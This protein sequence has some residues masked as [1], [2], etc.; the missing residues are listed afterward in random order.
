MKVVLREDKSGVSEVVG[1]ILILAMTVVLFST[2]IL[3]V[4]NIP[5]PTAQNRLD[6]QATLNPIYSPSTGQEIGV[7]ITL[8]HTGGEALQPFS[9]VIYIQDQKGTGTPT[10]DVLHLSLWHNAVSPNGLLDGTDSVWNI[11]ERWAYQNNTMRSTDKITVTIVDTAQGVVLFNSQLTPPPG[12]RP[13]VFLNVWADRIPATPTIDPLQSGQPIYIMA[14]VSDPDGDLNPNS[15]FATL[16]MFYGTGDSCAQPQ[17]MN[18]QGSNGD[19]V[20]NDGTFTLWRSCINSASLSWDGALVLLNATDMK[21]HQTTTRFTLHITLGPGGSTGGGNAGSGRPPNLRWNGNQGYNI[22]NAT[23]WDQLGFAAQETRTFKPSETVVVVVGSLTLENT[24]GVNS[25]NLWDPY[26]GSPQQAVVYGSSK[27]VG[28]GTVPSNT[29]AFSFYEFVNG[30]Y[31]YTYRFTLNTPTQTNFYVTPPSHPPYYYFASYPLSV[32]LT[33]STGDRFTTTDSVNIT[34]ATGYMRQ[35]PK[36]ETFSDSGFTHPAT[37]FAST[38]TMYVQVEMLTVNANASSTIAFGNIMIQDYSGGYELNRAPTNG[39]YSNLPICPPSGSCSST[40]LAFWSIPSVNSYRFAVNLARVNQDPWVAGNQSY[41]FVLSSVKDSDESYTSVSTQISVQAP[42][43][44][45]DI[46]T[47]NAEGTNSAW[48]TKDYAYFY[49]DYNGYDAWKKLRVDYCYAGSSTSGVAGSGSTC[50]QSTGV[51]VAFGD[52]WHDGTL[53]VAEAF[54]AKSG[55]AVEVFRRTVDATGAVV[56]LPVF[57]NV[58]A[59]PCTAITAADVTGDGIPEVICGGANGWVWYYANNGNWTTVYVD[60]PSSAPAILSIKVADFNGDGW[61][62]IVVSG[63]NGYLKWYPNLGYGKFQNSGITDNWFAV[64]EQTVIGNITSGSYLNTYVQDGSYEQ[65]TES[66]LNVP[67][68]TG[69]A[70]NGQF[71]SSTSGWTFVPAYNSSF[72]SWGSPGSGG[73][74]GYA[75]IATTFRASSTVAGYWYQPFTVSG[76]PPYTISFSAQYELPTNGATGGGAV[77]FYAFVGS[78]SGVPPVNPT[79]CDDTGT[80]PCWTSGPITGQPGW[81]STGTIGITGQVTAPG[82]YYLKLAMYATYLSSGSNSAGGFDNVVLNW[83]STPGSTSALQQY[84]KIGPLP[85]RPGTAFT[86][87]LRGHISSSADYD[88]YTFAYSTNVVGSDPT[89]GT[90]TTMLTLSAASDTNYAFPLP[91]SVA[92]LTVWIRAVDTN[93]NVGSSALDSLYVDYMSINAN[94]PAGTTGIT[95]ANPGDSSTVNA[96]SA[97]KANAD[98]YADLAVGTSAGHVFLYWGSAG[99]LTVPA[100]A[101]YGTPG[102]VSV[103]G[104]A[105]GNFTTNYGSTLALAVGYDSTVVVIRTNSAPTVLRTLPTYSP[106]NDPITAFGVGDINGDGWADVVVGTAGGHL[107]LWENLGQST[108]WT[109]PVSIDVIGSTYYSLA[110]GATTNSQYMGSN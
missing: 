48:G 110:I 51:Q 49:Q 82:T 60:Q 106:S 85:T 81:T 42:L 27:T 21:G 11:G 9:T 54:N 109:Q 94:T 30:Y 79:G 40:S 53:G 86:L 23:Q 3:W 2:I 83:S 24:F 102:G 8:Q 107:W 12:T 63:P 103:A 58:P 97:M 96:L 95:L 13:P 70:T 44:K 31:I 108:Q 1:T 73:S 39:I 92:G 87:N 36:I 47:G 32:L 35:F 84:W 20:A 45:M 19:L 10:T 37:H 88:N 50:P 33:S 100:S 57:N 105:W 41:S 56:Y 52:F 5:T 34:S 17:Q 69:S 25:F 66:S 75:R 46:V 99:G 93:R 15:V 77:T 7:N 89:T 101:W 91:T 18:D 22:F 64:G 16:T 55:Y 68:A 59:S 78:T 28:T 14:Q 43:Y 104:L 62:D 80:G 71:N 4:S 26:S 72:G 29:Q 65:V 90:Y 6:I 61:N 67:L 76:S 38:Q 98:A 74:G